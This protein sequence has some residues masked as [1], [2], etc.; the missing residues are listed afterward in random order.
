MYNIPVLKV[1]DLKS[2]KV[3]GCF[4]SRDKTAGDPLNILQTGFIETEPKFS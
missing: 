1:V 3:T 2:P 4:T